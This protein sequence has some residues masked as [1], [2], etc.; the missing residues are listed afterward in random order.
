MSFKGSIIKTPKVSCP[1]CGRDFAKPGLA[2]HMRFVHGHSTDLIK[3]SEL[4][5][6]F[7][8]TLRDVQVKYN[9]AVAR[10]KELEAALSDAQIGKEPQMSKG[11]SLKASKAFRCTLMNENS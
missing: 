1:E 6:S 5:S 4:Q 3:I 2:G 10:I 9:T 7:D 8:A 11:C